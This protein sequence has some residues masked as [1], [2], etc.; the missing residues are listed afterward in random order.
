MYSD[1]EERRKETKLDNE[2]FLSTRMPSLTIHV[3]NRGNS[4]NKREIRHEDNS[5]WQANNSSWQHDDRD[6]RG[7]HY[8]PRTESLKSNYFNR[9]ISPISFDQKNR[10]V[11]VFNR[12]T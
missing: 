7:T 6:Q 11:S 9:P 5:R 8:T 4:K 10:H 3:D 2:S 1:L 12:L